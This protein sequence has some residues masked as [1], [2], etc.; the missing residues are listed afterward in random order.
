MISWRQRL[1][2][3][4]R[5]SHTGCEQQGGVSAFERGQ[6]CLGLIERRI[7]IARVDAARAVLIVGVPQERRG[8]VNGRRDRARLLVHPSEPLGGNAGGLH[9]SFSARSGV[10]HDGSIQKECAPQYERTA[11]PSADSNA[12]WGFDQPQ[13]FDSQRYRHPRR[14]HENARDRTRSE[15]DTLFFAGTDFHP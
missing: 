7:V 1:E 6:H 10:L 8:G 4:G 3:C 11:S 15:S 13:S 9:V 2:H 5:R 14:G 12:A